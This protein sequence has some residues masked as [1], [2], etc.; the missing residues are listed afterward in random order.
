MDVD[1]HK[2]HADSRA[3]TDQ[4]NHFLNR[5]DGT[6]R[7]MQE[8]QTRQNAELLRNLNTT[9]NNNLNTIRNDIGRVENRVG[10]LENKV[11]T[12]ENKVS[13]V[14]NNI[15][16]L[17]KEQKKAKKTS[18]NRYYAMFVGIIIIGVLLGLSNDRQDKQ[19]NEITRKL[20]KL[21]LNVSGIS[22]RMDTMN[23]SVDGLNGSIIS[24]NN[25]VQKK[26]Y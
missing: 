9:M 4:W 22:G 15:A 10:R 26:N 21:S 11:E 13:R 25:G 5:I 16:N 12:I 3:E 17:K 20:D 1:D 19:A 2:M 6:L 23:T 24:M 7:Q 18:K 14:E 8:T